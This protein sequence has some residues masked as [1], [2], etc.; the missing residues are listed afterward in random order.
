MPKFTIFKLD[1]KKKPRVSR[2]M[3]CMVTFYDI[4]TTLKHKK[5]RGHFSRFENICIFCNEVSRKVKR[6]KMAVKVAIFYLDTSCSEHSLLMRYTRNL[7]N[8][9]AVGHFLRSQE[10]TKGQIVKWLSK[11]QL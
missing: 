7:L 9:N 1:Y 11:S 2:K 5:S 3:T 8:V 4:Y 10:V 6:W